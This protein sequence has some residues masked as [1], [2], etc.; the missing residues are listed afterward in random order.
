MW[1]MRTTGF[2]IHNMNLTRL[3]NQMPFAV[4]RHYNL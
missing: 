3:Q 2:K 1:T 4:M